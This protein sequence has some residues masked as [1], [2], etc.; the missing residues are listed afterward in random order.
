MSSPNAGQFLPK[1]AVHLFLPSGCS[2]GQAGPNGCPF[3]LR[4]QTVGQILA[5]SPSFGVIWVNLV[6]GPLRRRGARP[7]TGANAKPGTGEGRIVLPGT[8]AAAT[9]LLESKLLFAVPREKPSRIRLPLLHPQ[10]HFCGVKSHFP[11]L[12]MLHFPSLLFER[13]TKTNGENN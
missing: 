12:R 13:P 4:Q 10:A 11:V 2:R 1:T 7:P 8:R 5:P 9:G 6:P 3:A